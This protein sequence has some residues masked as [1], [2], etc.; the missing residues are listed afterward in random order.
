[1]STG[2]AELMTLE[3]WT[4]RE[5]ADRWRFSEDSIL[6]W[7]KSGKLAGKKIGGQFRVHRSAVEAFE[8][9]SVK[10]PPKRRRPLAAPIEDFIGAYPR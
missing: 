1:M 2:T 3:W 9:G 7:I 6:R 8:G 10:Q 4:V 5:C